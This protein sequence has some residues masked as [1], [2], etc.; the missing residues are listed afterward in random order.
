LIAILSIVVVLSSIAIVLAV[1]KIVK[2]PNVSI[3]KP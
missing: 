2:P 3:I 1:K